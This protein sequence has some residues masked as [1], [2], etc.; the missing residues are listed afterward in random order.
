[1]NTKTYR[2]EDPTGGGEDA[3][4]TLPVWADPPISVVARDQNGGRMEFD[5]DGEDED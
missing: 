2:Y 5:L 4:L 3:L 1:M